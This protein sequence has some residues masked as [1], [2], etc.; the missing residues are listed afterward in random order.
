M[1][2]SEWEE[3]T[4]RV[5]GQRIHLRIAGTSGPMV[6]MVHGFP[7]CWYSRRHQWT[8]CPVPAIAPWRCA[9]PVEGSIFR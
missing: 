2:L 5:D 4:V 9:I 8:R 6:L 3:C 1:P 7:Q